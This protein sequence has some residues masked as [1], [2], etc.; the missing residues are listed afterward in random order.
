VHAPRIQA[1]TALAGLLLALVTGCSFAAGSAPSASP[2]PSPGD[3]AASVVPAPTTDLRPADTNGPSP[4]PTG[5]VVVG[6][7]ATASVDGSP[8]PPVVQPASLD[9]PVLDHDR[10]FD[11]ATIDD[12]QAVLDAA[13]ERIPTPG[14][15][16]AIRTRDGRV[17]LGTSGARQLAPRRPVTADTVFSIASITKT[18]VTAVV[19]Q[20][21]DEGKLSLDDPLSRYM[22]DF[23]RARRITIRMLLEHRSGIFNYFESPAYG[24]AAYGNPMRRWTTAGILRLVGKPYCQ[25]GACFHY[26]NTNFVL[27]GEV[28]ERV[29]GKPVSQQVRRRLLKPL[30]LDDTFWQPDE[31][32]PS[33]AAHGHL[34]GGGNTFFDQTGSGHVLPNMSATTIAASAGAMVSDGADL[35]RWVMALYGSDLVLPG[36]VRAAMMDFRPK[37]QYGLGTRTRVYDGRR[38]Y[39]HGGSLRG[40][41]D[42]VWYLPREGVS[43]VLLS[44]RGLYDPDRTVRQLLRTLWKHIDVPP[45][46][47]DRSK[48][49]H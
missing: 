34:W 9:E 27:L 46:R 48:N 2:L 1:R 36:D 32:T 8:V 22:P 5:P 38:A 40:Y 23:P 3:P 39:G 41:E 37:D 35:A 14:I 11:Q 43:I 25:P 24:Q 30:G 7:P 18:F 19:L 45:P 26:S 20:L 49:T 12:L 16:V 17:W 6:P 13:R 15:S 4:T 47:Y 44:N 10:S 28:I 31:T 29:T 33:N 21:V 42:Q